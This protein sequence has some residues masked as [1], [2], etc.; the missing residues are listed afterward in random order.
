[1]KNTPV[2]ATHKIIIF[3]VFICAAIMTSL[4]IFQLR[5][6][7]VRP[8]YSN[9][10]R[11]LF[12]VPRDLKP[13]N[14]VSGDNQAFTQQNLYRHWTLIFFGFTHCSNVCPTTLEMISRAYPELKKQ[15][16]NLQVVLVSLD[17]DRDTPQA[18]AQYTRTF[19]PDFIGTTGKLA[20]LRKLQ[21]QMGVYSA[22]DPATV[23]DK[24]YQI[25]HTAS[26]M[27]INPQGQWAGLYKF[28]LQPKQFAT[29]FSE[30]VR[31][32]DQTS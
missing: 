16:P 8:E 29:A 5:N 14:L 27:L 9:D 3:I 20:E 24:G 28:G 4:F 17:P 21:S 32:L 31:L 15:F 22:P 25:Q 13:F 6:K 1:M 18:L 26:I 19:N 7:P 30:S 11:T 23:S 10:V 2:I 12:P